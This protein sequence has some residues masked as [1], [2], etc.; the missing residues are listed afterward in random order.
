VIK[1][2]ISLNY[3]TNGLGLI[4]MKIRILVCDDHNLVREGISYM[5]KDYPEICIVGE[6]ADGAELIKQYEL[7]LPDVV[8]VDISMPVLSG[9]DAVKE[10]KVNYPGIKVLF[11]TVYNTEEYIYLALKIGALG[12]LGKEILGG[13]LFYAISEIYNGR[14]YFGPHYDDNRLQEII[15]KYDHHPMK[16]IINKKVKL[17][18]T[19]E[20]IITFISEGFSSAEIA[21]KLNLSKRTID[22]HRMNIMQKF[23]LKNTVSLIKYAII[24]TE[25]KNI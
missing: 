8:I 19:E 13:E 21:E 5:M 20:K 16:L 24:Y 15:N 2:T 22:G 23:E 10:L 17:S 11:L 12:L 6:A 3:Q 7:L 9:T 14:K 25:T 18:E 1:N 4:L